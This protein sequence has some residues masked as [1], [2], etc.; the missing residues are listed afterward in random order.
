[1]NHIKHIRIMLHAKSAVCLSICMNIDCWR[2]SIPYS[3]ISTTMNTNKSVKNDNQLK[4]NKEKQQKINFY[5]NEVDTRSY[6]V[7]IADGKEKFYNEK[8]ELLKF[9]GEMSWP[10]S[11]WH[12]RLF[13]VSFASW[14]QSFTIFANE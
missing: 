5:T 7:W 8:L 4:R 6:K 1:M 14:P 3:S 11:V 2:S 12:G 13:S 9:S 10:Y